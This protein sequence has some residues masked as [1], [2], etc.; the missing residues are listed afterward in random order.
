[1]VELS[2]GEIELLI[3]QFNIIENMASAFGEAVSKENVNFDVYDYTYLFE[4]YSSAVNRFE[5]LKGNTPFCLKKISINPE[6]MDTYGLRRNLYTMAIESKKAKAYLKG[7]KN[8]LISTTS[9]GELKSLRQ[10]IEKISIKLEPNIEKNYILAIDSFEDGHVLGASLIASR[11]IEYYLD[12]L[13]GK[14][15]EAQILSIRSKI[16]SYKEREDVRDLEQNMIKSSKFARNLLS[17]NIQAI[18]LA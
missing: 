10:Q 12:K 5:A 3:E 7:I 15:I 14:D 13:K 6:S 11:L 17:H 9:K 16:R 1:M 2:K 4:E 18:P 8:P